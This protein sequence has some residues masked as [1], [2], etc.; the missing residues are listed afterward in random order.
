[1][2]LQFSGKRTSY[3]IKDADVVD[4]PP[5]KDFNKAEILEDQR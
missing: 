5:S 3:I 2:I 1:M 4:Y